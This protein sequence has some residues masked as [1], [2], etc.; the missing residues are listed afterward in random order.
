MPANNPKSPHKPNLS[1]T[2]PKQKAREWYEQ[3]VEWMKK[4]G[5]DDELFLRLRAEAAAL[6]G[7]PIVAQPSEEHTTLGQNVTA[8][9]RE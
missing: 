9:G 8:E 2:S 1:E 7:L 3:A 4:N 6:L 5:S